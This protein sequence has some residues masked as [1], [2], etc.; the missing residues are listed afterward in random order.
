MREAAGKRTSIQNDPTDYH[1]WK[2][3][4]FFSDR[5]DHLHQRVGERRM[6]RLETDGY[7]LV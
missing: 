3:F 5:L 7:A 4:G 6:H 2:P 1:A